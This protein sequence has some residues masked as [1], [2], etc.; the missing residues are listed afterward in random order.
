MNS[1]VKIAIP[2]ILGLLL[3]STAISAATGPYTGCL[4]T[5]VGKFTP[6]GIFYN[7]QLGTTPI[8]T[9]NSDLQISVYDKSYIDNVINIL[10][11]QINSIINRI[12]NLENDPYPK[13]YSIPYNVTRF[14][15]DSGDNQ[16]ATLTFTLPKDAIVQIQTDG[17]LIDWRGYAA[18]NF[19]VDTNNCVDLPIRMV[20]Q[21]RL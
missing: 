5:K 9:C 7:F 11:I 16:F 12:S 15:V 10:Q 21:W 1:K 13:L 18:V 20:W 4:A 3:I 2:V 17:M 6:N 14:N 8:S 19:D